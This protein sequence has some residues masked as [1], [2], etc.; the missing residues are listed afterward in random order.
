MGRGGYKQINKALNICAFEDYLD[1]QVANLPKLND[2][3]QISPRVRRILGQNEGK[4]TLQG[5]NTYIVGTGRERLIIDTGQGIPEYADLIDA[6]LADSSVVL[7]HVLLTHWHGDH[8][9]G[10]PDLLRL[11]PHLSDSIYKH[12]PGEGQQPIADGQVFRVEGATVRAV[13]APGHSHDHMCFILE[14]ENAMFTGDNVLGHGTAAVEVLPT[15][16][17]SLRAMQSHGCAIGYPAH[18]EVIRNLPAKIDLE[19]RIKE[20]REEK[21]LQALARVRQEQRRA[22]PSAKG[23]V[24]V[25]QLAT[26]MYGEKLGEQVREK[27]IEPFMDEILRKLAGD[28]KVAFELKAGQRKWF[29]LT[30]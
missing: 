10:V 2:V 15:W 18:G 4:F 14:E 28:G 29:A 9:G 7:S 26:I 13:H 22:T 23:S 30:A 17:Q 8:T 5:T 25:R 21:I 24:T 1:S 12:T 6:D 11:Y 16:M 19:I 20:R 3:E 27:A